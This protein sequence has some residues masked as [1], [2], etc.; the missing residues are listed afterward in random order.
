MN[1][2]ISV[3]KTS[4]KQE[5]K[6]IVNSLMSVVS[7]SV[8]MYI[9][10]QLW[11]YIYGGSGVGSVINGYTLKMMIW[12]LIMAEIIAYSVNP[13]TI[14]RIMSNDIK[15]GKIAYLLNKPYNYYTYQI[16]STLGFISWKL[17]F[18][19][20]TGLLV[21]FLLLGPIPNFSLFY[22]FPIFLTIVLSIIVCAAM[23]GVIALISFWVE[24]ASPFTWITEK[25]LMLF[26][27]FF[28]VEFFPSFIQP[29]ILY[30][31]IYSI[32]TGPSKLLAN[33]SWDL[34]ANVLISQVAYVIIFII[35][36]L[37]VFK[38]GIRKVNVHGG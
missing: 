17:L 16:F 29:L 27:L 34:F 8:I 15:S 1:K 31:P 20:P 10:A 19:F 3:F 36:G 11:S 33:F 28:P 21:G 9:F 4:F 35:V 24:E 32:Y 22:L 25:F 5:S 38:R 7:F 12:Y 18:L 6:T 37:F 23:F 30:T 26:G 14:T 13:R 2:Y